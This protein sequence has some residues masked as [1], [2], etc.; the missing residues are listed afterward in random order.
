[1]GEV[2]KTYVQLNMDCLDAGFHFEGMF[3]FKIVHNSMLFTLG[4]PG[5]PTGG[6]GSRSRFC[7]FL[8]IFRDH[9]KSNILES[10]ADSVGSGGPNQLPLIVDC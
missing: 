10:L 5:A 8:I 2:A 3:E 4:V 7:L 9:S 6:I 1:M